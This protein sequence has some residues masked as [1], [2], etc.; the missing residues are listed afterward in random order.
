VVVPQPDKT[1]RITTTNTRLVNLLT[2][3]MFSR[4]VAQPSPNDRAM[5]R[6]LCICGSEADFGRPLADGG[7]FP[8]ST[9]CR[10]SSLAAIRQII[11]T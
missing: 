8:V 1:A 10:P 7:V 5:G 9:R 11:L 2:I 3:F 4:E 6:L